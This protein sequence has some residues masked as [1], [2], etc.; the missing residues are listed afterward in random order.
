[1]KNQLL[2]M[3]ITIGSLVLPILVQLVEKV[4]PVIE[5]VAA[6]IEK[7]PVLTQWIITVVAIVSALVV[8]IATL[9]AGLVG[10]IGVFAAILS[11]IGLVVTALVAIGTAVTVLISHWEGLKWM[12]TEAVAFM[13]EA[14]AN[15]AIDLAEK[16][17]I[18]EEAAKRLLKVLIEA[19][20]FAARATVGAIPVVGPVINA[21]T[22]ATG[23]YASGPTIVG[24]QGPE[25][26]NVPRGSYVN[27]ARDTDRMMRQG[28]QPVVQKIEINLGG[29]TV[30]EEADEDRLIAKLARQIQLIS[31]QAA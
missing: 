1:L 16:F 30:R 21:A 20:E 5:A 25:I 4:K 8:G 27:H 24:E 18:A 22:R 9:T 14:I 31:L 28:G 3:A 19:A 6:W 10:I 29:V 15:F 17:G 7:H 12:V 26:V 11:P 23:G 2:D 13:K